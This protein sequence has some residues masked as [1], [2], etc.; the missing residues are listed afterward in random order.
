MKKTIL[1]LV[2]LLCGNVIFAQIT[3]I[4][5]SPVKIIFNKSGKEMRAQRYNVI[6]YIDEKKKTIKELRASETYVYDIIKKQTEDEIKAYVYYDPFF[7][8]Y[9]TMI[10]RPDVNMIEI[11]DKDM[12]T[13]YKIIYIKQF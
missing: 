8:I 9:N 7:K 4:K 13:L 1:I 10:I 5:C 2:V 3:K 12:T 6:F 11:G